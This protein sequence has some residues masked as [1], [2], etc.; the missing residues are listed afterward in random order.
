[1]TVTNLFATDQFCVP[2][3]GGGSFADIPAL[4][5]WFLVGGPAPALQPNGWEHSGRRYERVIVLFVDAFGWR[6][7]ERFQDHPL[8]QR[9]VVN[10][11]VTQLTSQFPS[12]TSAHVTT[13]Y[14]GQPVGR[15]GVYEWF[16]YEPALDAV[17]APLLFSFAGDKQ[18]ETLLATGIGAEHLLPAPEF[19]AGLLEQ[20]VSIT[21]FQPREF[22]QSTYTTRLMMGATVRPNLTLAEALVNV[23]LQVTGTQ[24]KVCSVLYFG[25]IDTVGHVH[26]PDAPQMDAEI[27]AF[28]TVVERWLRRE[29]DGKVQDTLLMLFADHGQVAMDPKTT[30]YLNRSRIFSQLAPLLRTDRGGRVVAPAG[31]PRDFFLHVRDDAVDDAQALLTRFLAGRA[32]VAPT[33]ALIDAGY[34]GPVPVAEVFR[35][36]VGNLVILP[37]AGESVYWYEQDRFEQKFFGHHGGLTRAEME[38]PLG[39]AVV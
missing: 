20:G 38:I 37:Y 6:F 5:R 26:G 11:S 25:D 36:R 18:R 28:L 17:I 10:G 24:G 27:D 35:R 12:T 33:A 3:Y 16:Y 31:G 32:E 19:I 7:F 1:M 30:I 2:R 15:H 13:L 8:L 29:I 9:F 39:L 4:L 23:R 22:A 14:T 34:F 21:A